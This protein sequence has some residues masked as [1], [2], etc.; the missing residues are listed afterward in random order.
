M[1][2]NTSG[3]AEQF[4]AADADHRQRHRSAG[5]ALR[6]IAC[7][8]SA[9]GRQGGADAEAEHDR[10]GD[11]A[12]S[13]RRLRRPAAAWRSTPRMPSGRHDRDRALGEGAGHADLGG[14]GVRQPGR[15]EQTLSRRPGAGPSGSRKAAIGCPAPT[16]T[17]PWVAWKFPKP[18]QTR[19]MVDRHEAGR[20]N[21]ARLPGHLGPAAD[22]QGLQ[23]GA[24]GH[25]AGRR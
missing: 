10:R 25:R 24:S 13:G 19:A 15:P 20:A 9:D 14:R 23:P 8:S 6:G 2:A 1:S 3:Q 7:L 18:A 16:S 11:P 5:L 21:A 12:G 22:R 17:S 4:I